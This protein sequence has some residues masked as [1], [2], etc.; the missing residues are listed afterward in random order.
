[1][2]LI[3]RHYLQSWF[4]IDFVSIIPFDTLTL[5]LGESFSKMKAIKA[6]RLLR[7]LKLAKIFRSFALYD[8]YKAKLAIPLNVVSLFQNCMKMVVAAHWFAC[9]WIMCAT[10]YAVCSAILIAWRR[11]HLPV[12][13]IRQSNRRS[14]G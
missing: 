10:S 3:V 14:H 7:L 11:A 9:V 4:I 6:I 12:T 5:V 13:A 8:K 2:H 1:M